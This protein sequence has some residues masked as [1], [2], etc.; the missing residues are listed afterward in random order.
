MENFQ[1][2]EI[3]DEI[4]FVAY[5]DI[6]GFSTRVRADFDDTTELYE[7]FARLLTQL[8]SKETRTSIF[9][10]SIIITSKD[11]M[12]L[13]EVVNVLWF[14]AQTHFFIIRGGIARGRIW[15]KITPYHTQL[16][17]DALIRAVEIEKS[18]RH[19]AVVIDESIDVGLNFWIPRFSEGSAIAPVLYYQNLK[20][21]SPFGRYW[22]A[23][24]LPRYQHL[25]EAAGA[26]HYHKYDWLIGLHEAVRN[27]E[28]LVPPHI[29][30]LL[31]REGV[32]KMRNA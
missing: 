5:C 24:A 20:I 19:P 21:V 14:A 2:Q 12:R 4:G 26:Q 10:D 15:Q 13:V 7:T 22:F 32:I 16:V 17:S 27:D 11:L 1:L 29:I 25:K 31:L 6:L 30:A 18:V 23:S 28:D 9:S 3:S 8:E